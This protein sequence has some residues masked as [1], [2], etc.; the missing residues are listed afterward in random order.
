MRCRQLSSCGLFAATIGL[1][2]CGAC[3][4]T[5]CRESRTT[6]ER[7]NLACAAWL[8][9]LAACELASEIVR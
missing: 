8:A 6:S 3:A 5:S 7:I 1:P 9:K 4:G 2:V